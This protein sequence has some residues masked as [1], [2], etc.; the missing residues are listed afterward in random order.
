MSKIEIDIPKDMERAL[1]DA[2]P[3]EDKAAVLLRL[4][5]VAI[6]RDLVLAGAKTAALPKKSLVEMANEIRARMPSI[7]QQEIR[8]I[9]EEGRH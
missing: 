1:D 3:G 9:R 8:R 2:F 7:S 4:A 5:Q 6:A